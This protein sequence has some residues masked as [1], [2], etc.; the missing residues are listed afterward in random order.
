MSGPGVV[1]RSEIS[2]TLALR[3]SDRVQK[4]LIGHFGQISRT[5]HLQCAVPAMRVPHFVSSLDSATI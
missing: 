2:R 1:H 4:V 3:Y 5:K